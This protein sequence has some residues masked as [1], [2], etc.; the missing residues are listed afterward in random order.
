MIRTDG[1]W[2]LAIIWKTK[3][4]LFP[5]LRRTPLSGGV[6]RPGMRAAWRRYPSVK[7]TNDSAHAKSPTHSRSA[8]ACCGVLRRRGAPSDRSP[9]R[10]PWVSRRPAGKLRRGARAIG[11]RRSPPALS[12]L[13]GLP[14]CSN[15]I[16][17][18]RAMG[19][20]LAPLRGFSKCRLSIGDTCTKIWPISRGGT[21]SCR[22]RES[23]TPRTRCMV[24]ARERGCRAAPNCQAGD[25]THESGS[26]H[27]PS[28]SLPPNLHPPA[29]IG[30]KQQP[31]RGQSPHGLSRPFISPHF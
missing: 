31:A 5:Q 2:R 13:T 18:A 9:W 22:L 28:V 19:Y 26:Q 11:T 6:P 21:P 29:K 4:T 27:Q 16:P 10:Q 3:W 30:S 20:G 25:L 12:P 1:S 7:W 8:S 24:V 23:L 15:V 17:T 14:V